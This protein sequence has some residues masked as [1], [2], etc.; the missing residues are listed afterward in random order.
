MSAE[1]MSEAA[2]AFEALLR[3]PYGEPLPAEQELHS[4]VRRYAEEGGDL[5]ATIQW[6]QALTAIASYRGLTPTVRLLAEL[7]ADVH[8]PAN[9]GLRPLHAAASQGHPETAR[10]LVQLRAVEA[11]MLLCALRQ[12][13]TLPVNRGEHIAAIPGDHQLGERGH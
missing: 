6:G 2:A 10:L 9:G 1:L 3:T 13:L 12:D 4:T 8:K 7:R 11:P 5:D